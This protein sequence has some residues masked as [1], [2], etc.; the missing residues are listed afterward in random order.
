MGWGGARTVDQLKVA[1]RNHTRLNETLF[2]L[3]PPLSTHSTASLRVLWSR[4]EGRQL[5]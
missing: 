4:C 5:E 3:P 1:Q 2:L